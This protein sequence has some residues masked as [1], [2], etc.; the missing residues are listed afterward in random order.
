VHP[1][2]RNHPLNIHP[3]DSATHGRLRNRYLGEPRFGLLE[4]YWHGTPHG[5]KV[6]TG[7]AIGHAA[8]A[9]KAKAD[10]K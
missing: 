8:S 6:A 10:R 7:S 5:S 3:M 4:R 2:I 1:A 9:A